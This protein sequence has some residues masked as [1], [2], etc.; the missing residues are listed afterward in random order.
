MVG[1]VS[2]PISLLNIII[3]MIITMPGGG[4]ADQAGKESGTLDPGLA[5]A[6]EKIEGPVPGPLQELIVNADTTFRPELLPLHWRG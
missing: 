4:I 5:D 3:G 1:W 6:T 2:A